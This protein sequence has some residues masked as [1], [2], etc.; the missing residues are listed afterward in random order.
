MTRL[1]LADDHPFFLAGVES[2]LRNTAFETVAMLKDGQEVLDQLPSLRVDIVVLDVNMPGQTGIDVLREMRAGGDRRPVV[3]LTASISDAHLL[4]ALQLGVQG[5]V[6]KDGAQNLLLDCLNAVRQGE[7]WIERALMQRALDVKIQ[8]SDRAPSL[9]KLTSRE[10]VL[11]GLVGKSLRNRDIAKEMRITEGTVK[12]ALHRVYEKLG[13][14]SRTELALLAME[15][16]T[17]NE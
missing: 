6:L 16:H 8:G 1:L 7:R 12:V 5:I 10:R 2:V 3:L 17:S 9:S 4:E 14:G 11:V 13:V 15:E